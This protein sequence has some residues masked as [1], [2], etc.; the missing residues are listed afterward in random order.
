MP[1]QSLNEAERYDSYEAYFNAARALASQYSG[2]GIS[3]V[4]NA[5]SRAAGAPDP[6]IQNSRVKK[7]SSLPVDYG[8]DEIAAMV[9]EA[10]SNELPLRQTAHVLEWTAYPYRKLRT[11]Y[12]AL[13]G[14]YYYHY[15]AYVKTKD[16]AKSETLWREGTLL[17]KLNKRF[18]P[19]VFAR[20]A[21]GE[22]LQ[23][24]K[25]AYTPRYSIDKPHNKINYAFFQQFPSDWWK[26]VGFNSTSKYTVMFDMV[27]FLSTPGADWRQYGDLF[28]PYLAD[29]D[30]T[31]YP[32]SDRV[33]D[34]LG[35]SFV[36]AS[37]NCVQGA[38][39]RQYSFDIAKFN[40]LRK[41]AAGNP[42]LYNANGRWSYWVTLPVDRCWVME[43]D[44]S[45]RTVA[46]P[47]A[48]LF[49]TFDQLAALEDVQLQIIQN[50][51]VQI[52]LG[53]IPYRDNAEANTSD[54]YKLSPAGRA[55]FHAYWSQLLAQA[56]TSGIG[57]YSGPFE[58]LH[59]ESLQES[60]NATNITTEGYA[61]AIEKSGLSGVLPISDNP[62]AGAVDISARIEEQYCKPVLSQIQRM[63]EH[64]YDTLGLKH[65]WRFNFVDSGLIS[66]EADLENCRKGITQGMLSETFRYLAL[67]GMSIWD[68]L[69]MSRVVMESGILDMRIPPLTSYTAKSGAQ[70]PP[71]PD[72]QGGRP[73]TTIEDVESGNGGESTEDSIDAS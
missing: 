24:G 60:P 68:D 55:M 26:I 43:A 51:L 72:N 42:Q 29:F 8:K 62:R 1:Q 36:Y 23:E 34:G 65:E 69:S 70:L 4:F 54:S 17:D 45:T 48:G 49:L 35:K 21:V 33:P 63:M 2:L 66:K 47:F 31:L 22:C 32:V 10:D 52:L 61:Y 59:M 13:T 25:V 30:S 16:E 7:I 53:E 58:N 37:R 14:Y 44:D 11:T 64:I 46:P 19:N 20:Q 6:F 56:N 41:N 12:Q 40:S 71:N 67:R 73:Q 18:R 27:Y 15:P 28:E 3:N 5:W 38:D 57:F 39:G 9:R 50:P